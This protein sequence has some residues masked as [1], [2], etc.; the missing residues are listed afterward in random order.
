MTINTLPTA[1]LRTMSP[2]DFVAAANTFLAALPT[3]SSQVNADLSALLTLS[4]LVSTSTTSLTIGTGSKSLTVQTSKAYLANQAVRIYSTATP[5]NY[6]DGTVTSYDS[7]TGALVVNV[8]AT[9]GS[10]TLAAWT[11]ILNGGL[12]TTVD[13]NAAVALRALLAGSASQVFSVGAATAAAHA[14]SRSFGDARYAAFA[15]IGSQI[16]GWTYSN[17]GSDATND[18]DIAAGVG[19]DS[20][21]A[22]LIVGSALTKQSDAAWAVG[23]NAGML[24]TG[25]VG[26]NDYYL[27]AIARSD[28]GVV[29]YLSSLSS[30]APTMPASYDY[31][32]LIGWFKRAGGTIVAFKTYEIGGGG[33]EFLWAVPTLDVD[34]ANT[35]TTSRRTD[36]VKVPLNFSVVAHV[37]VRMYDASAA[38][39][40]WIGCPDHTDAAPSTTAA[41]LA[42]AASVPTAESTD[43][44]MFIRTS[45]T[46]TIA[47]RAD[48]ATVDQYRVSTL[49]FTWARR[50]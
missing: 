37:N 33:L 21:R 6:M 31:K 25:T 8:T 47:A 34:L 4:Q 50:A 49:G 16:S 29:D 15:A 35:L 22:Y 41:P 38:V 19:M 2:A 45:A 42:N 17:N 14:V 23:T 3:F 40:A 10:G 11:V 1:P 43:R 20:T 24:D 46:G 32:R 26:N 44:Q 48:V 18:I 12:A 27:W 9:N 5:D 28:T 36:A 39:L 30:T 7:G 13:L